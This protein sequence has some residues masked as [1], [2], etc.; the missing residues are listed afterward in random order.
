MELQA[1]FIDRDGTLGGSDT[2]IYPGEFELFPFSAEAL[3]MLHDARIPV[4]SFTNQPGIARGEA[5]LD[6]F[7]KELIS[8]GFDH[9]CICPHTPDEHCSC[10]KPSPEML[11]NA[12]KQHGLQLDKCA[13]IG[14]RWTDMVAAHAAGCIKVLVTTGSGNKDYLRYSNNEYFGDWLKAIPNYVAENLL[15]AVRWL[16]T[17]PSAQL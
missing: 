4:F 15:G 12:A 11:I 2:V 7:H 8:F 14:D 3:T 1:V 9:I 10:R 13:V 16:L 17:E 6:D 5:T